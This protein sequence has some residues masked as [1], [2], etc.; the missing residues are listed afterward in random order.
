MPGSV[1]GDPAVDA[2][3][4][5]EGNVCVVP[6]RHSLA[7]LD[8]ARWAAAGLMNDRGATI[9]AVTTGGDDIADA[10]VRVAMVRLDAATYDSLRRIGFDILSLEI[11]LRPVR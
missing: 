7:R 10:R 6:A 11:W 3:R 8:R 9:H 1:G 4:Y 5:Y 2:S